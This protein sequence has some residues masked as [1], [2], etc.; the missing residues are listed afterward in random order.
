MPFIRGRIIPEL[1]STGRT[2]R[3]LDVLLW[4]KDAERPSTLKIFDELEQLRAYLNHF[5]LPTCLIRILIPT[6]DPKTISVMNK[7]GVSTLTVES[8]RD[9]SRISKPVL[10]KLIDDLKAPAATALACDADCIITDIMEWLPYIE[11]FGKLGIFL[12]SPD[13]L[14]R[15]SEI[16]VRGHDVPWAFSYKAWFET[17]TGFYHLSESQMFQPGMNLLNL[18]LT[19]GVSSPALEIARSLVYNRLENLCFTRDRLLFYEMQQ[20]VATRH[21][22]KRQQFSS[23]VAY[24]LNHYY[25]L[26]YGAFDHVAVLVNALFNL[27]VNEKRAGA[28]NPEFL[29]ALKAKLP[30]L[31]AL[32]EE[33]EHTSFISRIGAVRH[34]AAHR[35]VVTPQMVVQEPDHEP[36]VAELDED[37]R[38][39]GLEDVLNLFPSGP[40]R[41]HFREM[42]RNNARMARYQRETLM[43]N[44]LLIE[45]EGKWCFI[46]PL[47]DTAWNFDRCL[48]FLDDVFAEC[49]AALP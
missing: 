47:T 48:R 36:T 12:T 34:Q 15:Q 21:K 29:S 28:R 5:D 4:L 42:M 30:R 35:A 6:G 8:V 41:E 1:E 33:P 26:L 9:F 14:L 17:W 37:I 19:K 22:W 2:K 24:Y 40:S 10:D 44:V 38:K 7:T 43:E 13:L 49:S 16:F 32:F 27:G 39:A 20:A 11:D 23:E 3:T 45:L 18:C 25:L 31:H 46:H